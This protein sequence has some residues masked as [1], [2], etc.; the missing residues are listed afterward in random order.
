MN[1]TC[2]I[3]EDEPLARNLLTEYVKKIPY[4]NLLKACSNPGCD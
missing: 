4:L 2:M 1:I 3:V